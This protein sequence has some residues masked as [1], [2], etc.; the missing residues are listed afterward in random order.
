M[1][2]LD[3][4][5]VFT[6]IVEARSFTKV[7]ADIGL[8]RSTL[9]DA[10][11]GLE[12]RLGATL[13]HRTTRVVRPTSDGRAFYQ[14]C[15]AI[16]SEVE[17]AENAFSGSTPRG[18]L[19]I[20][21]HGILARHFLLPA[22]PTFLSANPGLEIL[23][24]EGD[25]LADL[26]R[27]GV[28]CALRVGAPVDSDMIGRKLADLE[29]ITCAS[30]AYLKEYGTPQT[31]DDLR[32]HQMIGFQSTATGAVMPLEFQTTDGLKKMLLPAPVIVNGA[33]TLAH[34][35]R[36]G[37][38]L[39]QKPRYSA[40]ED[41]AKGHL[42]EVMSHMPPSPSPVSVFYTRDRHLSLRVRT[43]IDWTVTLF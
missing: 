34:C 13:L 40:A 12:D 9:S 6:R 17:D 24:R 21:V 32:N 38:G 26:L 14:R 2:R 41:I 3:A 20:E 4:M 28:D 31:L 42:V 25:R 37:L 7:A 1:D 18:Q 15:L 35:A 39:I 27:E 43:F 33:D 11:R 36:L 19:R 23:I 22:L 30:P 10:I 5:E 29:E 8:P 16:L